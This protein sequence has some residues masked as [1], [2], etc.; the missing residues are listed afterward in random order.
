MHLRDKVELAVVRAGCPPERR[1]FK[2][3]VTLARFRNGAPP[4]IGNFIQAYDRLSIGP[5]T[6]DAFTLFRSHLGSEKAY[7]EP[8]AEYPLVSGWRPA[9]LA[10]PD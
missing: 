2:P 8:L 1:K 7:Y 3:H 10:D 6:V 4:R 5:F 9:D